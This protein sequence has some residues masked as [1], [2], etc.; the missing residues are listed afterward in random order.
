VKVVMNF[1]VL[2]KAEGFLLSGQQDGLWFVELA[3]VGII[4]IPT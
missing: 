3:S 2:Y 1:L 4:N